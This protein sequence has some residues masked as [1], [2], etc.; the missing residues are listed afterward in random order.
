[1]GLGIET[2]SIGPDTMVV[3]HNGKEFMR[4]LPDRKTLD[5]DWDFI[6]EVAIDLQ[7]RDPSQPIELWESYA[8]LAWCAHEAST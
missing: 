5:A 4:I 6:A 7:Q 8:L 3:A 2:T 1:M